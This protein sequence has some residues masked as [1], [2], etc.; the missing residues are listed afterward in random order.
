MG[1]FATATT[2]PVAQSRAEIESMLVKY[3]A[4]HFTSGWGPAHSEVAFRIR[5]IH[6]RFI[7]PI[8]DK[9]DAKFKSKWINVR[10]RKKVKHFTPHQSEKLHEQEIKSRWR[11]L[12]LVVKAK[13]EAVD[14][15]ISTVEQEFLAFIVLP[16]TELTIGDWMAENA[17]PAIRSGTAPR[18]LE[19]A[20]QKPRIVQLEEA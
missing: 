2:V 13:L 15:G 14:I 20:P 7:L 5:D 3:G 17:M 12:A 1:R 8:P 4:S 16:G 11:A 9:D 19:A 18:M 10:G 6:V